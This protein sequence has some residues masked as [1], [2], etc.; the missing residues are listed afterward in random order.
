MKKRF[1]SSEL[2]YVC[3]VFASTFIVTAVM[4]YAYPHEWAELPATLAF[5]DF[6]ADTIPALRNIRQHI[7]PYTT[8]WGVFY[9]VFLSLAPVY[10]LF[11]Y[12]GSFFLSES[13]Y[14]KLV[15]DISWLR[16]LSICSI[17]LG[18]GLYILNF[19]L[20]SLGFPFGTYLNQ[21]SNFFPKLVLSWS[22]T[23]GIF[24]YLGQSAGAILQKFKL[25][26]LRSTI[27]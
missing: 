27:Y 25:D 6:L 7:P 8:Y 18:C 4:T 16:L 20:T 3:V 2:H 12:L 17:S 15:L 1:L 23:M 24:Y 9:A 22:M 10:I 26:F 11:G 19:P 13:R 14:Q 5:V 21:I